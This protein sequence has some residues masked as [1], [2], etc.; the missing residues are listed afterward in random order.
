MGLNAAAFLLAWGSDHLVVLARNGLHLANVL[1]AMQA[2]LDI[3]V[4]L[5]PY[6]HTLFQKAKQWQWCILIP[7]HAVLYLDKN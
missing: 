1:H 4:T 5:V 7:S 6:M 3:S 2:S